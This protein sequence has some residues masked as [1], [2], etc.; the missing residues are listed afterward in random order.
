MNDPGR[1]KCDIQQF[2]LPSQSL[3]LA[4][5]WDKIELVENCL[6]NY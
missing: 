3:I 5:N 4:T 6:Q 1:I 2:I